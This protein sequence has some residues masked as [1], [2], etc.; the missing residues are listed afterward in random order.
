M[1]LEK[2]TMRLLLP[3]GRSTVTF[4]KPS[5]LRFPFRFTH[6]PRT[7]ERWGIN[8]EKRT[9]KCSLIFPPCTHTIQT[10][11]FR[12]ES[13]LGTDTFRINYMPFVKPSLFSLLLGH[14]RDEW[15]PNDHFGLLALLIS[16]L[17]IYTIY[18]EKKGGRH[19]VRSATIETSHFSRA[20]RGLWFQF[21]SE[22]FSSLFLSSPLFS[23]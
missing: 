16:S 14:G 5:V 13:V 19:A 11:K 6:D 12:R 23:S 7:N 3:H 2:R 9:N 1:A 4:P 8:V 15:L 22:E 21:R 18:S 20:G 17:H 10:D